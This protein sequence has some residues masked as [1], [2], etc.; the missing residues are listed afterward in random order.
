MTVSAIPRTPYGLP[1][2]RGRRR[3]L[4]LAVLGWT[5]VI[6]ASLT[7]AGWRALRWADRTL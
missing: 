7:V 1:A 3:R 5:L 2:R 4:G 6:L